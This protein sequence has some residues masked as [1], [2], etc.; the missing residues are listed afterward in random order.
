[1]SIAAESELLKPAEVRDVCGGVAR[2][3]DQSRILAEHGLPFKVVGRRV[4]LSRH[5]LREW[6]AGRVAAPSKAPRLELV[7]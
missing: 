2:L 5:H 4:V 7:K 6:L 3:A 1:M